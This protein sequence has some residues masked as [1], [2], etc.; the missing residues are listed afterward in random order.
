MDGAKV[1]KWVDDKLHGGRDNGLVYSP[2]PYMILIFRI[3]IL[4]LLI[5]SID[6]EIEITL[7]SLYRCFDVSGKDQHYTL[8]IHSSTVT[9]TVNFLT[10]LK[11]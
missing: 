3:S 2:N 4:I 7:N 10:C 9:V 5:L 6:T 8:M 1:C 11:D